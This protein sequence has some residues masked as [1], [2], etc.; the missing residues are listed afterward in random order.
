MIASYSGRRLSQHCA[1][2]KFKFRIMSVLVYQLVKHWPVRHCL[3]VR[4]DPR[5]AHRKP[6]HIDVNSTA[7]C[8]LSTVTLRFYIYM[9]L[10]CIKFTGFYTGLYC[11][12]SYCIL[13]C[14]ILYCIMSYYIITTIIYTLCP[15]KTPPVY[16]S[17]NSVK[18]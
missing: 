6:D 12:V 15:Q 10:L 16:F 4:R 8:F 9:I 13:Y 11:I 14:I 2:Y 17:N 7:S 5:V 18:N 3:L 1:S